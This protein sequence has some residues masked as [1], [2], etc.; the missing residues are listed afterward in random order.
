MKK[1]AVRA[2]LDLLAQAADMDVD[3]VGARIEVVI[4]H[5]FE[6]HGPGHRLMLVA[7]QIFEKPELA[8]LELDLP[9]AAIDPARQE[10]H[11]EI[12]A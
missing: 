7:Q 1:R 4:P 6:K 9:S 11:G 10:V 5:P 12:A 2:A 8:R 3:D